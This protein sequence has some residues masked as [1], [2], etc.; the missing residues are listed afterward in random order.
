MQAVTQ[1]YSSL[2]YTS[3]QN[4]LP[5]A[6]GRSTISQNSSSEQSSSI[7]NE[8]NVSLSSRGKDLS[9]NRSTKNV[10]GQNDSSLSDNNKNS[11][12][13]ELTQDELKL[14]TE[15]Q[16][17]DKEVRTHE[18]AHLAAAGQYAAGGAS[19]SYTAGPN[20][21]RY[22]NSGSVPIDLGEEKTPEETIQKMR[23]VKRAALAPANPSGA[24]RRI[25]AQASSKE[26][27]AMKEIQTDSLA[28]P[29]DSLEEDDDKI[30][31]T[32]LQKTDE[33]ET[34]QTNAQPQQ[35][36]N[37]SRKTMTSAYRSIA[38]LAT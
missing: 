5:F 36:S 9:K 28:I 21:K 23:T 33:T 14:V 22:A 12:Q 31:S 24:D 35:T 13:Q 20:G 25:A 3:I 15:L 30:S 10:P 1:S 2:A 34:K 32:N 19:F 38:A 37:Y 6:G 29:T 17:R 27:Q 8:E 4:G 16:K 11:Y 26:V 7:G 18:Q